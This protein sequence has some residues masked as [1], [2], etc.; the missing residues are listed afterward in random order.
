MAI[1][2]YFFNA[3][4][5]GRYRKQ[6]VGFWLTF[7]LFILFIP[8]T[9][10]MVSL[11]VLGALPTFQE[12][13]NPRTA[14]AT[15]IYS[16]DS[17]LLGKF[18]S[19]NR[20]NVK[21][22]DLSPNLVNALV[23]TEDVRF[24]SHPGI[25]G[26]GLLRAIAFMMIGDNKGGA[27]T[28]SQQLAKNL[29]HGVS[30]RNIVERL[31]KKLKEQLIAV[32]LESRYT[33][34]EIMAMYLNTV[35]FNDN[36]FG[37]SSAAYTYF[38]KSPSDLDIEE[39]AVLVGMLQNPSRYNPRRFPERSTYRRNT[40]LGQ[41]KK[42]GYITDET[43]ETLSNFDDCPIVLNFQKSSHTEGMA[44]YFREVL[45]LELAKWANLPEN[46]K[47]D[48][49]KYDIYSDGLKIYTTINS[50]VQ[51]Y[52]EEAVHEHLTVLQDEFFKH[53]KD[54]D[55]F[56]DEKDKKYFLG[57]VKKSDRYQ[58]LK[59][60]GLAHDSI[61]KVLHTPIRMKV[62]THRGELD[63]LMSPYDSIYYH[64]M[65]LQT[66]FL[67]VNPEDGSIMAWVGGTDYKYFQYDHIHSRRQVGSTFK[68]FI[69]SK[70][71]ENGISP[72]FRITD[73]PVTFEDYNNWTPKNS[74]E[75]SNERLTL[76][77]C[78]A[79][80]KNTCSAY[81]MKQLGPQVVIQ[82]MRE[83]GITAPIDAVPAICLGSVDISA[84][85]MAGAYTVF[86]NKG[87][88][89]QPNYI[90]SIY[91]KDGLQVYKTT[92]ESHDVMS[93]QQAYVLVELLRYVVNH[94]SGGRLRFRYKITADVCGKTGTTNDNT[95]GWFMGF[96][97]QFIG[98]VWTGGEDRVIR[99]R[100]TALGQGANMALPIWGLFA[101]KLY[102]DK[103]LGFTE[104]AR[105]PY[106][107]GKLPVELDCSKYKDA[108]TLPGGNNP[109]TPGAWD[110]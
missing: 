22:N 17:V 87:V 53:W 93:E 52:A 5:W 66:G 49:S 61:M 34:E 84:W 96:T 42:Y 80:S 81:L 15:E 10:W 64:R 74:D 54:K 76:F 63:T 65:I 102:A 75:Y 48:S 109:N 19:Q 2:N 58:D 104:S 13:E 46:M 28:I 57:L 100:S 97:P 8:F 91:T 1:F 43:Y 20:T 77:E 70:A 41:M 21:F 26:R 86:A 23:A 67:V 90:S 105:F 4:L 3:P 59:E 95:D 60:G 7:L 31:M 45:R 35:E 108:S 55:I 16:A 50:K 6:I 39:A 82:M 32:R 69:Y 101:Q 79:K 44:T 98:A 9:F 106:P 29:F 18:Y 12:L 47:L 103:S 92:P 107:E 110:N 71:I 24:Y 72:C 40:V 88:Y 78:L 27:S 56:A 89:S 62:F 37:I 68:P 33:K 85:E 14:L 73:A 51:R 99:F 94:G 36:A 83:M 30:S 38:K 25:D 11:G